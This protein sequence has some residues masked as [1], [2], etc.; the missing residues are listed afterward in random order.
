V[1]SA[2]ET[3]GWQLLHQVKVLKLQAFD[4]C[5]AK[6]YSGLRM[7]D[8]MKT[9]LVAKTARTQHRGLPCKHTYT[10]KTCFV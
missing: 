4:C 9:G 1:Q 6:Q 10:N 7:Q 5:M 8:C 2:L 3:A